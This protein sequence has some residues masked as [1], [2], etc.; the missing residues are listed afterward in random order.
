MQTINFIYKLVKYNLKIVFAG[1]FIWF[2]LAAFAV[3]LLLMF[4][5]AWRK[6][7]IESYVVYQVLFFP[8]FLLI[9]Y[10]TV[11]GIQNDHDSGTLELIF[12]I[13]DYR[14]KIWGFRLLMFFIAVF[15]I[16]VIFAAI[17]GVLLCPVNPWEIAA[18]LQFPVLFSGCLAFMFS[19]ITR[20]GN[21][22]ATLSII[23]CILLP[24]FF[25]DQLSNTMW[26]I[27]INP[28]SQ[29]ESMH[30]VIWNAMIIKNRIFLS[31]GAAIFLMTG[32]LNLQNR[33]K[34]IS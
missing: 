3:F 24:L 15:I 18:Q 9:F 31:A 11:F 14:Y 29:P 20:S 7:D 8:S 32:L 12:G 16:T 17:A 23:F 4:E 13:P 26:N 28:F 19:T 2:L 22:T 27:Y 34:F 21:G 5:T 10:P 33:E 6:S 1:K 25:E 30:P